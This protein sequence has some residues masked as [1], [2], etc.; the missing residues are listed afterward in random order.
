MVHIIVQDMVGDMA[1]DIPDMEEDMAEDMR[2]ILLIINLPSTFR[3]PRGVGDG[4]D[5]IQVTDSLGASEN[6][7]FGGCTNRCMNMRWVFCKLVREKM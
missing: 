7:K 4:T 2:L 6:V 5:L 1:G 3:R